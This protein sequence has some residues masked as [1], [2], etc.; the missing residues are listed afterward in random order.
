MDTAQELVE[1]AL[2]L[3]ERTAKLK[4]A[5]PV[6]VVYRPL[7][8]AWRPHEAYLR[9]HG[10]GE[11]RVVFLGMNPG[12]FGMAQ[13]GVPFGEVKAVRDWV[14]VCAPV[15]HPAVEHPKRPITGFACKRS[16]VSGK[17]LWG[18]FAQR[19]GTAEN[20]FREH[21]VFNYCPLLFMDEGGRNLTPDKFKGESAEKMFAAC[22]THLRRVVADVRA[23]WVVGVGAFAEERAR[24]AL[25]GHGVAIARIP[26]PSPAN[27]S[28]NKDWAG[29]ATKAMLKQGVW[30]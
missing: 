26:H 18:L 15:D 12:P 11:K 1:A 3:A 7:E 4:F 24:Q 29:A 17:R 23:E 19:F 27:P 9:R 20:F 28:A 16:E 25:L 5:P 13:T 2:E 10:R 14:G 21:I 30:S 6:A 22:D 8:Y